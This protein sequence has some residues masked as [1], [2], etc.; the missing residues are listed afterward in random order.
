MTAPALT[1]DDPHSPRPEVWDEQR[2][3]SLLADVGEAGL[4]DV[5]RLFMADLPFLQAQLSDAVAKGNARAARAVLALALDSA[6]AL[7]L[8]ALA[9]CVRSLSADPLAPGNPDL[10]ALEAARIRFVPSLKHAS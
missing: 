7:G 8:A 4:R 3:A 9:G 2:L 1:D 6:E 10:L 5:L